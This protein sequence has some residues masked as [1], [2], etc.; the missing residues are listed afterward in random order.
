MTTP[1]EVI[2][3][4]ARK[5]GDFIIRSYV[6]AERIVETLKEAGFAIVPIAAAEERDRLREAFKQ[7]GGY[8]RAIDDGAVEIRLIVTREDFKHLPG[9]WEANAR[10]ALKETSK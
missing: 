5:R 3:Y 7:G 2:V 9:D 6:D 10:Q 1:T 8:I 4:T